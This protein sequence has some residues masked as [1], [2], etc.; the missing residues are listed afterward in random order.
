VTLLGALQ[1]LYRDRTFQ[2][3]LYKLTEDTIQLERIAEAPWNAPKKDKYVEFKRM[4]LT[5]GLLFGHGLSVMKKYSEMTSF[6][7]VKIE[8]ALSILMF[9]GMD[10]ETI[11]DIMRGIILDPAMKTSGKVDHEFSVFGF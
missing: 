3:D 10:K 4:N 2:R 6:N 9:V 7:V 5:R 8:M 11:I 1:D